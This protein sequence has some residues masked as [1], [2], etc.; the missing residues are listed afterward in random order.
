MSLAPSPSSSRGQIIIQPPYFTSSTFIHP[1]REDIDQLIQLYCHQYAK[2]H[3][4]HPFTLFKEI[5]VSQGWTW[6]HF[7]VFD[8]RSR[9]AFLRV[10]IRLFLER[11]S[12]NETPLN[13]V[14]ALFGLYTMLSTQPSTSAPPLH[15]FAHVQVTRDVYDE[16]LS[17]PNTLT[18]EY[19]MPIRP[20]AISVLSALLKAQRFHVLP[21][22]D[23]HPLNPRELP[24]EIFV[25]DIEPGTVEP[26]TSASSGLASKKK[27]RPSKRSKTKRARDSLASL[28][29]WLDCTNYTYQSSHAAGSTEPALVVTTH[30]LLSHSP[31]T[32][33][34]NYRS[35]KSYLLDAIDPNFPYSVP[36][37]SETSTGREALARANE[38]V[39]ERMKKI[40]DEASAQGLEVGGEGG[41]RT[42]LQR[43][44]R[45][46]RELG[47]TAARGGRGGILGLLEGAGI[48]EG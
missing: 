1:A 17:L 44:E 33:R 42:G 26:S 43:V 48:V 23:L 36:G 46:A 34:D 8:A 24:R 45:G 12:A 14:T 27:G 4:T 5:W 6:I 25:Q 39:V 3:P 47:D 16:I 31:V 18:S 41:E 7:K 11:I 10:V 19:L 30:I 13:R 15:A 22:A 37:T 28:D 40:D 38:A 35:Q 29:R 32:T 21:G 2:T 9:E 20:Y